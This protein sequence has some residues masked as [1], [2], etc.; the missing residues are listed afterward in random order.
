MASAMASPPPREGAKNVLPT[1]LESV[2]IFPN[3]GAQISLDTEFF[4]ETGAK[5]K[6]QQ[7]FDGKKPVIFIMAYYGCPMLCGLMLNAARDAFTDF[8][9]PISDRYRVVTISIDPLEEPELAAA[10]K[11]NLLKDWKPATKAGAEAGWHFL[12][13]SKAASEKIAAE[14]GFKFRFNQEDGEYAHGPGLFFISPYGKL[15]RVLH[16]IQFSVQDLKLALLESSQGK[17]GG[18]AEK[19]MLFCY[20]Y[21]PKANKYGLLATRLMKVGGAITVLI[22]AL[23]YLGIYLR[24][25]SSKG[26]VS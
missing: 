16:G 17:I 21:D 12:V 22:I 6:L 25:R 18:I 11:T 19:I 9:W 1:E 26:M 3:L 13:G 15:T 10:K 2:G 14:L 24:R 20:S 7:Y 23:M 4:D 8:E 5:V